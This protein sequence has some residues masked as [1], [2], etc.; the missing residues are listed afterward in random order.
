[1]ERR[2]FGTFH[3][4]KYQ[5]GETYIV[6]VVLLGVLAMFALIHC[7]AASDFDISRMVQRWSDDAAEPFQY[8]VSQHEVSHQA[9]SQHDIFQQK[10]ESPQ[11]LTHNPQIVGHLDSNYLPEISGAIPVFSPNGGW[12]VLNDGG[13]PAVLLRLLPSGRVTHRVM[14][15]GYR[16][17]DWEDLAY[18]DWA[19]QSYVLIADTGDNNAK[20]SEVGLIIAP[21]PTLTMDSTAPAPIKDLRVLPERR[22]RLQYPGGARDVEAVAVDAHSQKI[23]LLSKRD[24]PARLYSLPLATV[25]A[26]SRQQAAQ[27]ILNPSLEMAVSAISDHFK[28]PLFS[29]LLGF[30]VTRPTAMDVM[31][32]PKSGV[33]RLA[34][35]TYSYLYVF[36]K[37][38]HETY[39][40][41]L[42]RSPLVIHL[43]KL[44]QAEA[45]SLSADGRSVTIFSEGL[46]TPIL[47]WSLPGLQV[48]ML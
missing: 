3:Y 30:V 16:N 8:E 26:L 18:F 40:E 4:V 38:K 6:T 48:P 41:A 35:L 5:R 10:M 12:W 14:V 36:D 15:S 11:A 2:L 7:L 9:I 42:G 21:M 46:S 13:H 31:T 28:T 27:T 43:R 29:A 22:L 45:V 19:G 23:L 24:N 47:R 20:R 39:T 34:I 25:M 37:S 17:Y 33:S 44:P 32:D 1:M